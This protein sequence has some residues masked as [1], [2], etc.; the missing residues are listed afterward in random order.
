MKRSRAGS[1]LC[2]DQRCV[3]GADGFIWGTWARGFPQRF[4][5]VSG[6]LE[7]ESVLK[8]L[9]QFD[10]AV[11]YHLIHT[12]ALLALASL[13]VGTRHLPTLGVT[14]VCVGL[15]L[16]SGSLYALV[17]TNT[18][19][20]GAITPVGGLCLDRRLGCCWPG[21]HDPRRRMIGVRSLCSVESGFV[22]R[23]TKSASSL[24]ENIT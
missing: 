8:R 7:Q 21:W 18:P 14:V 11:R 3:G 1:S 4:L 2:W 24:R 6:G 9:D 15:L 22:R 23:S 16:F 19:V 12:V 10:V 20:L 5:V 17:L 13:T